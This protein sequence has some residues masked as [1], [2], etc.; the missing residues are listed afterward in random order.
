M[1]EENTRERILASVVDT[2]ARSG[3]AGTG[4]RDLASAAGVSHRTLLY[5]FGSRDALVLEAL[6][7]LRDRQF[8]QLTHTL[9]NPGATPPP[10]DLARGVW[11]NISAS[12]SSDW[13][14]LFFEAYVA[15]LRAPDAYE[16]FLDGVVHRWVGLID[17]IFEEQW[18]HLE[19]D[20]AGTLLLAALRG[21]HLDL[22]AT[23]DRARVERALETLLRFFAPPAPTEGERSR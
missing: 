10:Q 21:L 8:A 5:H 13:F 6:R 15:S 11:K 7:E 9:G 14:K 12:E 16:E 1:P 22:L 20:E 19:N 3:M 4:L 17:A 23:G 2:L 18:P